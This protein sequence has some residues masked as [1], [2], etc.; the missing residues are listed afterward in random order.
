[1]NM[2]R[3][4]CPHDCPDTCATLT[5]VVD[6]RAVRFVADPDHEFT[7]GWLCAKVRP[8]LDRVY[9]PERLT[10]PLR[11]VGEKGSGEWAPVSWDEAIGEITDRWKGIIAE[12]GGGAILP[13]SY[14]GTLGL[15]QNIVTATRLFNRMG[16]CGL[17]RTICDAA[18][19]AAVRAT[20][21][22]NWAPDLRDVL[23]TDVIILWGNNPASTGPHFMPILRDAQR[24]GTKVVVIDPRRTLTSRGADV[25]V[26]LRPGTDAAFALAMVNVLFAE[27]LADIEFLER[28]T[29]GWEALR[30]RAAGYT[31]EIAEGI[32]GVAAE[33]IVA[34][35]RLFGRAKRGMVKFADGVQ[36]HLTGGQSVRALMMLPV[37]T[38]QVGKRGGGLYYSMSGHLGWD[39][40]A[41]GHAGECPPTPRVVNM[42]RLGAALTGEV[43]GG[44]I[45]SLYVFNANP[46]GSTPNARK[47]VEGLKRE[48][49]FTVVH[50]LF[51]TDTAQYADIVLPATT[52][53]E[54]VDLHKPYGHRNLQYNHQ[55]IEP[56]AGAKSNWEV[57]RLLAAG[58]GYGEPWLHASVE[59]VIDEVLTV[60]R[61]KS[62]RLAGVTLE[63]LQAEGTVPMVF[64]PEWVP[65]AD[66]VFPTPSGKIEIE[67]AAMA[68]MGV[69]ALPDYV[70]VEGLVDP[71]DGPFVLV[72]GAAH[73]F[74]SSSLANLPK[75][76]R[77]EGTPFVEVNPAD[78]A[79]K[80]IVDGGSV[81]LW[82]RRG[83]VTLRAV[84][85]EDVA[86]GTVVSPKGRWAN[87]SGG[88]NINWLTSDAL[89]DI[90]GQ[91][92]FHSTRVNIAAG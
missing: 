1:M 80:G 73:H 6:G 10:Q 18:A 54:Q 49:L 34:V 61:E 60:T 40:G 88:E 59:E 51:M 31:P 24:N 89:A 52:Q 53:L 35:A 44:P 74:T 83:A 15:V 28:N 3:G 70:S 56:L 87:R 69:D 62:P 46:V 86:A 76:E 26:Q 78:A 41:I 77:K 91:S 20:F 27:G 48:D 2:I 19:N 14:S 29:I 63:R 85:T 9:H 47:I 81:R 11:R 21:G 55:A 42:N 37:V 4:C 22:A 36:R 13:Y 75:L 25:M 84:V 64:D 8:Y 72:S 92:T 67:S 32:T 66:G 65:F 90:A 58:M 57:S 50:E 5:E 39:S 16:A 43:S 82:N 7:Q 79:A 12:S 17:D 33:E 68:A 23:Q 38:G 30:E 71:E 45:R